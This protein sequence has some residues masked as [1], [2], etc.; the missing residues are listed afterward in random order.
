LEIDLMARQLIVVDIETSG[1][2]DFD[3]PVEIAWHNVDTG[4]R[5]WFVPAHDRDWVLAYGEP[6]ALALNRYRERLVA[7]LHDDGTKLARL[8]R[9]LHGHA[10]AGANPRFDAGHLST[11]WLIHDLVPG[12]PWHH[13]LPDLENYAAG[14]FGIDPRELPSQAKV[15]ELLGVPPGDHTAAGD[16]AAAVECFHALMEKAAQR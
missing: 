8:H 1:L 3:V 9:V 6:E 12:E 5:D 2:R 16:V 11:L 13:R 7:Q 15:C 10:L 14:A 4:E